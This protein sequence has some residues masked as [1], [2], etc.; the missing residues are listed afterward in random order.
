MVRPVPD[1]ELV[2]DD[3]EVL[4]DDGERAF[5]DWTENLFWSWVGKP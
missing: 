1:E 2:V 4:D 5:S 3:N